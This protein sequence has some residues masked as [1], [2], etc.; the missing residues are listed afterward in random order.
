MSPPAYDL[1]VRNVRLAGPA[2]GWRPVAGWLACAGTRIAA[3][4]SRADIEPRAAKVIDGA[5]CVLLPGLRNAHTHSTE[6]LARGNGDGLDLTAWLAAIWPRLD[7]LAPAQVAVAI[8]FGALL[9][10]RC[11]ITSVVDHFRRN[12]MSDEV[13]A[14]AIDAYEQ[15]GLRVLLAIMVRDRLGPNRQAVSAPH[16]RSLETATVQLERIAAAVRRPSSDRVSI[17]I[18]PSAAFRCT[19]EMLAGVTALSQSRGLPVHVHA[20]ESRDEV[21]DEMHTFGETAFER[22]HRLGVLG[23]RTACAHCIWLQPQDLDI[24]AETRAVVVHNPVSNLRLK[25]GIADVPAMLARGVNVAV[26]TDGAASNDGVD[27]WEVLKFAALLPRRTDD[28]STPVENAIL[29]DA[30]TVS[31]AAA[32]IDGGMPLTA[33]ARADFCLY[34]TREAPFTTDERFA[35]ALVLSGPRRPSHVVIDGKLVLQDGAFLHVDEERIV[36]E[37]RDLAQE[38]AA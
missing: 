29:L 24:L 13:I 9:S 32:L 25:A 34:P 19:D 16:L 30:A 21:A 14:A 6:I 37:A 18:G 12:P 22:M 36:R 17:G 15:A 4:G 27:L 26:G 33:G 10:I 31:G 28:A 1:L 20:A 5:G 3:V 38:L 23:E 7:S 2:S 11:G 8:R 35:A